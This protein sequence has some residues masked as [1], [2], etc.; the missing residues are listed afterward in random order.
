MT[1]KEIAKQFNQQIQKEF[2]KLIGPKVERKV[3]IGE[4]FI[5]ETYVNKRLK[6][7]LGYDRLED[8]F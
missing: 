4:K 7:R 2:V 5:V 8:V 3:Y 6:S 1:S